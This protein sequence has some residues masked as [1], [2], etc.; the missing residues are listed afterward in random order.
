MPHGFSC[1]LKRG[2][3]SF[4]GEP[5][6]RLENLLDRFAAGEFSQNHFHSDA[7]SPNDRLSKHQIR[8]G[9]DQSVCH[10]VDP[11]SVMIANRSKYT[12]VHSSGQSN[13]QQTYPG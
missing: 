12:G 4:T 9:L 2:Q 3:D 6:M 10:G 1:I 5:W 8:I 7:S 11:L 13:G